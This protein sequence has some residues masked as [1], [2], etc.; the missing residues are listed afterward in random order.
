MLTSNRLDTAASYLP[1]AAR[2]PIE[3]LQQIY[4]CLS[5][6]NFDAARHTCRLWLFASLDKSLLTSQLIRGGWQAG[7]EQ[8]LQEAADYFARKC[9]QTAGPSTPQVDSTNNSRTVSV[10]WILSKRLAAETRFCAD[11]RGIEFSHASSTG[12]HALDRMIALRAVRPPRMKPL[13][14]RGAIPA[15]PPATF[16]VSGCGKFVLLTQDRLVFIYTLQNSEA[17]IRP[18]T[19][20]FCHRRIVKVSMD[21]SC[22]R[23]AVA[24]LLEGRIGMCCEVDIDKHAPPTSD[25]LRPSM[26]LSDFRNFD[27]RTTSRPGRHNT[28]QPRVDFDLFSTTRS[29]LSPQ[30]ESYRRRGH[31]LGRSSD[32]TYMIGSALTLTDSNC[33]NGS[34]EEFNPPV[35]NASLNR[36]FPDKS[37]SDRITKSESE[38]HSFN[39][40]DPISGVAVSS[41]VGARRIYKNLCSIHDPP[42]SVAICPQRQCVAFGCKTGVELQWIDASRGSTLSRYLVLWTSSYPS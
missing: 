17:G 41:E 19:S 29:Q 8:D 11:W 18:L 4:H 38:Q 37:V 34:G 15:I 35:P 13:A 42:S 23:Y 31:P 2:L 30:A 32:S 33:H 25:R 22:G 40:F 28:G 6:S 39:N 10:E 16:T 5:S 20:I 12:K 36:F 21:T 1:A 7:A 24:I 9:R 27:V 26:S 14:C 3:I